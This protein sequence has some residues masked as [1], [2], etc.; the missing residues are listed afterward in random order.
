MASK[1]GRPPTKGAFK[2]GDDP[3]RNHNGQINKAAVQFKHAIRDLIV[4]EGNKPKTVT[5]PETGE[6]TTLTK[7]EWVVLMAYSAAISGDAKARDFIVERVEGKVSQPISLD[8]MT[9]EQRLQYVS[10]L[11]AR[12]GFVLKPPEGE[13]IP[14]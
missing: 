10:E 11:L 8:Q 13:G 7:I 14:S 9:E 12:S 4:T 2:K 6:K 3:R 5:N 1:K